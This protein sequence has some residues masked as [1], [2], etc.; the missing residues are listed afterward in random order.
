M[1]LSIPE[2]ISLIVY[3]NTKWISLVG[4]TAVAHNL[5]E[6]AATLVEQLLRRLNGDA[7]SPAVHI[8]LDPFIVERKSVRTL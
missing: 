3:D 8:V 6:I 4:L 5:E 7:S 1:E 2:D